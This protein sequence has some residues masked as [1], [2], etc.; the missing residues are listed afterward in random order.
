MN[1]IKQILKNVIYSWAHRRLLTFKYLIFKYP[2]TSSTTKKQLGVF[3]D[4]KL[5]FDKN[6]ENICQ[7]TS[8][9]SNALVRLVNYKD[10]PKRRIFM[11]AFLMLNLII[12]LLFGCFTI[13]HLTAKLTGY[14]SAV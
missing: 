10:L 14:M 13:V 9:K 11:N 5:K 1:K 3:I 6:V 12:A 2:I 8:R 4:N 7:K